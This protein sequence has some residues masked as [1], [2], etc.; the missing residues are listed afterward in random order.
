VSRVAIVA[1]GYAGGLAGADLM[2]TG[3]ARELAAR[4]HQV[5]LLTGTVPALTTVPPQAAGPLGNA[6]PTGIVALDWRA[7]QAGRSELPWAP[8]L[9]HVFDLGK[10]EPHSF[11]AELATR[12]RASLVLTPATAIEAWP[13]A[14]AAAESLRAANVVLALTPAEAA[15]LR[16]YLS[17]AAKLEI[18]GQAA[19]PPVP[20][21]Q[22]GLRRRLG[23]TGP[24]V[25]FLGRRLPSKGHSELLAAARLVRRS[26]PQLRVLLAGPGGS[27]ASEAGVTDLGSVSAATK[28]DLLALCDILCLP[29]RADVFPVVFVEAWWLA[30]PVIS[31]DF[32]GAGDVVR[33]GRDG[34]V[35]PTDPEWIAQALKLLLRD[36]GQRAALGQA[37]RDRVESELNWTAVTSR[38]ER[39]Y[40][41][42]VG[43]GPR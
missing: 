30:K 15:R 38:I 2:A 7:V 36:P 9:V 33:H 29:S 39:G 40:L 10:P 17:V 37:G 25:L 26:V 28:A 20:S 12:Y 32:A 8:E 14:D 16:P 41:T 24:A 1:H 18:I 4:G 22:D 6:L 21:D 31:G 19:D 23:L 5:A 11:A 3:T 43:A 42:A 27:D 34:L 35:G 13:D